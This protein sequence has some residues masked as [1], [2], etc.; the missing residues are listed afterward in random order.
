MLVLAKNG[1]RMHHLQPIQVMR[2]LFC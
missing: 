2:L 1:F